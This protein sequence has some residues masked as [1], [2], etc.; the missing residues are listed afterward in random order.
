M[1]RGQESLLID[2][3]TLHITIAPIVPGSRRSTVVL[4]PASPDELAAHESYMEELAKA[5]G[6]P[7]VWQQLHGQGSLMTTHA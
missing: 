7:V 1:T 2:D 5:S 4:M 6:R 3:D